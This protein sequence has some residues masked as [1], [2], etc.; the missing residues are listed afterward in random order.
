[1]RNTLSQSPRFSS[2]IGSIIDRSLPFSHLG[3]PFHPQSL[4]LPQAYFNS[5]LDRLQSTIASWQPRKLSLL[6]KV[7][8]LNSRLLSKLWYIAYLVS[9]PPSF[10][11]ALQ[12]SILA[13]L[14]D[15][16]HPQIAAATIFTPKEREGL[17]L[18]H[19]PSQYHAIKGWWLAHMSSPTP[20]SWLP[21]AK[22][23]LRVR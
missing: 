7:L 18:L 17:G 22:H 15:E 19:L 1:M 10:F 2:P 13:F 4:P 12:K 8:I 11:V 3:I 6:G 14:W 21:L 23:L 16:R 9:F 20:L 5:L